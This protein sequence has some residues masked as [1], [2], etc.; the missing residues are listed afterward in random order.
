M[1][2]FD[3]QKLLQRTVFGLLVV[4]CALLQHTR[5]AFFHI[6][7]VHAWL[8]VPV[9]VCIAMQE[10]RLPAGLFGAFAGVL[11]DCASVGAD[12]WYAVWLFVLGFVCSTLVALWIRNNARAALLLC[13]GA[14]GLTALFQWVCFVLLPGQPAAVHQF[15]SFSLPS[16]LFTLLFAL[17]VYGLCVLIH[18]ACVRQKQRS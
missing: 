1:R 5:G 2:T 11:W 6:G 7:F 14:L 15:F 8:L 16:A 13:G 12:G 3:K 4:L 17:P 10:K 18:R 9:V